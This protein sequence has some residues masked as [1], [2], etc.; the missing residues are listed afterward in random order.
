MLKVNKHK[1][2]WMSDEPHQESHANNDN[3]TEKDSN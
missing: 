3:I 1:V 2:V